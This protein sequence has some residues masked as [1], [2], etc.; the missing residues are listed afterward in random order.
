MDSA[1]NSIA[2]GQ[3]VRTYDQLRQD[4][5]V[6]DRDW[7][8]QPLVC[9]PLA[10]TNILLMYSGG[11]IGYS[12]MGVLDSGATLNRQHTRP[13][14]RCAGLRRLDEELLHEFDT[15]Q[16]N[17]GG[18]ESARVSTLTTFQQGFLGVK[19]HGALAGRVNMGGI[20][21]CKRNGQG[22]CRF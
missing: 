1:L 12:R 21:F 11:G 2:R 16:P 18:K 7:N 3:T 22:E 19:N 17:I 9:S 6:T 10:T 8:F 15:F 13:G 14:E 20:P 4:L 5:P